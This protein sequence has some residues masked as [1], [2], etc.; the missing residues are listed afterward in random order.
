MIECLSPARKTSAAR[1]RLSPRLAFLIISGSLETLD[2]LASSMGGIAS[3]SSAEFI[4]TSDRIL[5]LAKNL[6]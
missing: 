2:E 3:S 6:G 1:Y 4:N 5:R